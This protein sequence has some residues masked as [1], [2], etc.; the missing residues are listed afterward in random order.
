M[1]DYLQGIIDARQAKLNA[2]QN[3]HQEALR[4]REKQ[5]AEAMELKFK[6]A[7][8]NMH[9]REQRELLKSSHKGL[10]SGLH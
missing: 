5:R 4:Q 10:R 1:A 2:E 6:K 8:H 7:A 3:Q 9:I